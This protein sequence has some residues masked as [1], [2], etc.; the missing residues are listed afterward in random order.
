MMSGVMSGSKTEYG[1]HQAN[2]PRGEFGEVSKIE[3]EVFELKDALAQNNRI[4]ALLELADLVG[5]VE[6]FL[7]KHYPGFTIGDIGTMVAATKRA[8]QIGVRK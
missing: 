8:F 5:A 7:E 3:E 1:Y 2:I 6:G 4:M